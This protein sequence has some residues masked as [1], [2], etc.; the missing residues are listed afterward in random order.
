MAAS[1]KRRIVIK[2]CWVPD[3]LSVATDTTL[4]IKNKFETDT[5]LFWALKVV[6][7]S[8]IL[9]SDVY[10]TSAFSIAPNNYVQIRSKHLKWLA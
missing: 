3:S 4:F 8:P 1:A 6:T 9:T 7:L 5:L 10:Q 2:L